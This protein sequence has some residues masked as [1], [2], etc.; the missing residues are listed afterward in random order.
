MCPLTGSTFQ[1]IY[2]ATINGAH[3]LGIAKQIDSTETG[4]RADMIIPALVDY[5]Q[6]PYYFGRNP[7]VM[8][9]K[10]GKIVMKSNQFVDESDHDCCVSRELK[11]SYK[12][13]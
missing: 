5:N 11:S 2:T 9:I 8:T 1:A 3:A 7:V 6:P 4:R 10:H 13:V 12:T